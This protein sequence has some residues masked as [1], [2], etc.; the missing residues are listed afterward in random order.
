MIMSQES[1]LTGTI[2]LI[3]Q[4][5]GKKLTERNHGDRTRTL[6]CFS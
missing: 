4:V 5:A 2:T 3:I 6:V 1:K